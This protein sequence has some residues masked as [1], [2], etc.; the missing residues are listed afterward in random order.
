MV[1]RPS[2]SASSRGKKRE[3]AAAGEQQDRDDDAPHALLHMTLL[4]VYLFPFSETA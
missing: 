4:S 1:I 3:A 2:V